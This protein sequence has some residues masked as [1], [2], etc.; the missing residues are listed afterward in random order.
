MTTVPAHQA[1]A[2]S[3]INDTIREVGGALGVAI[4]GSLSAAVYRSHL[5][6]LLATAHVPAAVSHV[7][8]GSVAAANAVGAQAGGTRGHELVA[9]AHTAFVTSMADGMRVAAA[10]AVVAAVVS[11]FALGVRRPRPAAPALPAAS[12]DDAVAGPAPVLAC[13]D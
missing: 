7:A 11:F 4:I 3:A 1:G 5:G 9:A 13:T 6:G 12:A 8:T 2:G 10:V